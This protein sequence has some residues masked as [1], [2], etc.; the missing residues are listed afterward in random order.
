MENNYN[1]NAASHASENAKENASPHSAL[2]DAPIVQA[3]YGV[4]IPE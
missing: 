2:S 4:I 3:L 1:M